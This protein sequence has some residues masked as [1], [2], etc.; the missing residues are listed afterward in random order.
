MKDE[1][2]KDISLITYLIRCILIAGLYVVLGVFGHNVVLQQVSPVWPAAGFA[3]AMVLLFGYRISLAIWVG[4]FALT[5]FYTFFFQLTLTSILAAFGLATADLIFVLLSAWL[6][7]R[8]ANGIKMLD[9]VASTLFFIFLGAFLA[10]AVAAILGIMSFVF[11]GVVPMSLVGK[12]MFTWWLGDVSGVMIITP[13]ILAWRGWRWQKADIL[14]YTRGL[15]LFTLTG[16]ICL[17]VFWLPYPIEFIILIFL[18]WIIFRFGVRGATASTVLVSCIAI[19]GTTHGFGVFSLSSRV[20][21]L[22]LLDTFIIVIAITTLVLSSLLNERHRQTVDLIASMKEAEQAHRAAEAANKTKSSFLANMSHECFTP[23]NHIIGYSDLIKEELAD[24]PIENKQI[25]YL[26]G[27]LQ[28]IYHSGMQLRN[29]IR[30][31]LDVSNLEIGK[32][33][34]SVSEFNLA[35]LVW[36]TWNDIKKNYYNNNKFD[37]SLDD[38]LGNMIS[39]RSKIYS[40]LHTVL[41]NANK[42]TKNGEI[43]LK[44]ERVKTDEQDLVIFTVSD[45]GIGIASSDIEKLFEPFIQVDNSSTRK[46]GGVGLG[47]AISGRLC[48]LM[49]GGITVRSELNK[50]SIFTIQL[51]A[52]VVRSEHMS[53]NKGIGISQ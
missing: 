15:L 16:V 23:L 53:Q 4:E 24:L 33:E 37:I 38:H 48:K 46:Y 20:N 22:M 27:E 14:N 44:V 21:S 17:L 3:V 52:Q 29:I 11:A 34:L 30:D 49:G 41:E 45:T 25:E 35:E 42:F 36:D 47:L 43:T 6:I 26:N 50:G 1:D 2:N 39:D 40:I 9:S 28:K 8:F 31:I 13:L 19:W 51:P 18:I 10:S 32:I 7:N 5:I 12:S